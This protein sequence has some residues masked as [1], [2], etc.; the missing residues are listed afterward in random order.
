MGAPDLHLGT[1][2]LQLGPLTSA[3]GLQPSFR[4]A[5]LRRA[6][7]ACELQDPQV[8][9]PSAH[10]WGFHLLPQF[11]GLLLVALGRGVSHLATSCHLPPLT[12]GGGG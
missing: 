12:R 3:W 2:D 7:E 5:V 6:S 1:P 8:R 9:G 11:L 4:N 10:S